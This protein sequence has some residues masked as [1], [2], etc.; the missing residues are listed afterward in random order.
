MWKVITTKFLLIPSKI[1]IVAKCATRKSFGLCTR[2]FMFRHFVLAQIQSSK[3]GLVLMSFSTAT[4]LFLFRLRSA[5][6]LCWLLGL[7]ENLIQEL[8]QLWSRCSS[9]S[10]KICLHAVRSAQPPM[11]LGP[12]YLQL[13]RPIL[14]RCVF[15]LL[16]LP[17]PS[18]TSRKQFLWVIGRKEYAAIFLN[19]R[20]YSNKLQRLVQQV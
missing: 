8:S 6:K 5:L 16:D 9:T 12:W 15:G 4:T 13:Y 1:P 7:F 2:H 20:V 17:V 18:A 10:G 3:Q 14:F 19:T 11:Q